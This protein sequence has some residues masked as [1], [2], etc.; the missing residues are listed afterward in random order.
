MRCFPL[1][2]MVPPLAQCLHHSKRLHC[3][4]LPK[5]CLPLHSMVTPLVPFLHHSKRLHCCCLPKTCLPL[6]S[7]VPPLV[8]FLHHSKRL[9]CWVEGCRLPKHFLPL[10]L[11]ST[12]SRPRKH[13]LQT[14][15]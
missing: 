12:C 7:M 1:R 2:S 8:P 6:R 15:W 10:R 13:R 4:C 3:C 9:H 14:L 5:H 11:H